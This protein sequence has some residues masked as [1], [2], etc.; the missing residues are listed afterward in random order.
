MRSL[1]A[2]VISPQRRLVANLSLGFIG[3]SVAAVLIYPKAVALVSGGLAVLGTGAV[4]NLALVFGSL[5][6]LR[7]AQ[8]ARALVQRDLTRS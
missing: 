2:S 3:L 7:E 6:F 8:R 1:L 5:M 4:A